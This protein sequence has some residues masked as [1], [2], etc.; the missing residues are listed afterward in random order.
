MTNEKSV[1]HRTFSAMVDDVEAL[2]LVRECRE[3]EERYKSNFTSEILSTNASAYGLEII[4]NAQKIINKKDQL[5]LLLKIS[6]I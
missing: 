6:K 3:L 5:L 1:Y 2:S 4:R